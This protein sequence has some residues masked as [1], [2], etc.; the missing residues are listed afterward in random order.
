MNTSNAKADSYY[1]GCNPQLLDAVPRTAM[2]ILDVGC[3]EGRLGAALKKQV[4][5][6]QVLGIERE[7]EVAARAAQVLDRVLCIDLEAGQP[8]IAPGSLD[9]IIYGDV[10]EHLVDPERV[11][12]G[13]R[14]LLRPDGRI[15]CSVPNVQHH[16]IFTALMRGDLQYTSQGLLDWTHL[17][18]FTYATFTKLLLD[19]GYAPRLEAIARVPASYGFLKAARTLAE[20]VGASIDRTARY[21][22][23]F[24]YV[25]EGLPLDEP[26]RPGTPTDAAGGPEPPLTFVACV[27]DEA[28]LEAN[29]LSSPCLR[30]PSRHEL[31]LLRGCRSAAEGYNR[32]L[33]QAS[34][35]LVVFAHQDVYLPLGWEAR[36]HRAMR[37]AEKRVPSLGPVG[38]FGARRDGGSL[39]RFGYVVDRDTLLG[40]PG[41]LPA[42]VDTLDELLLVLRADSPLRFDERLGFH[43]Y[44]ADIGM[45]A[46]ECGTP[47]VV[48]DA[49]C[50][51]NSL[52]A[53]LSDAFYE[54]AQIFGKKWATQLPLATSVTDVTAKWLRSHVPRRPWPRSWVA[55]AQ[56]KVRASAA[57]RAGR[58]P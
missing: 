22:D 10:L 50:F 6:R 8:D 5:G 28:I 39:P 40:T 56:R 16:S 42:R 34:H 19:A 47:A 27:S 48:V 3:S 33:R 52:H 17:R 36:L 44:G 45:Q 37:D 23:A 29:L 13:H 26:A 1:Q 38:V 9:C 12:R 32:A 7:P 31:I 35:P 15:L 57:R 20:H 2:R 21:L 41:D 30:A 14:S 54:S 55:G 51:H 46:R 58:D 25:F 24:Q 53:H 49:L 43:F 18:F 4:A 11:L